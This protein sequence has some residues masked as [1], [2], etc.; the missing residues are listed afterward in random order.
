M[1]VSTTKSLHARWRTLPVGKVKLTDG[2]WFEKQAIN[3]RVSLRHGYRMLVQSGN[4][5][6]LR[7]AVGVKF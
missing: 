7:L 5:N 2:F 3:R 6:N 1:H 4:L